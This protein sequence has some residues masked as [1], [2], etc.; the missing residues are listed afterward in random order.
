[1]AGR[2]SQ[3]PLARAG[4]RP[5]GLAGRARSVGLGQEKQAEGGSKEE[6]GWADL[7]RLGQEEGGRCGLSW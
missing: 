7:G 2:P 6:G 4:G 1:M 5:P 3:W